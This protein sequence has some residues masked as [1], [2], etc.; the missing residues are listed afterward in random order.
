M[1]LRSFQSAQWLFPVVVTAHNLEEAIWLPAF[2]AEHAAQVPF[3]VSA[4]E[5]RFGVTALTIAAWT[6]TYL[7]WRNGRESVW[8]YGL[9]GYIVAMLLNVAAPHLIAAAVFRGYAPGVVTA[10]ALNLPVLSYLTFLALRERFVSG[11]KAALFGV[12]VPLGLVAA[13]ASLFALARS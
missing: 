6:V 7:S 3:V 2:V 10:V 5:F 8:T 13:I 12:A 9:F 4:S 11:R 1:S